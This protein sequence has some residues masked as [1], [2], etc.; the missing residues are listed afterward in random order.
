MRIQNMQ[1]V[2]AMHVRYT[3]SAKAAY[4]QVVEGGSNAQD[5]VCDYRYIQA[6]QGA[7]VGVP[8][9]AGCSNRVLAKGVKNEKVTGFDSIFVPCLMS[10]CL[11]VSCHHGDRVKLVKER[12][13]I[14]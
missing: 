4:W 9:R 3:G 5:S 14:S 7:L 13:E 2:S 11:I 1:Q 8:C 6:L 12:T 10:Q